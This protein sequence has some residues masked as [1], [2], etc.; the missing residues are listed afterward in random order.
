MQTLTTTPPQTQR[1]IFTVSELT[2]ALKGLLEEAFP[3]VWVEGEI[4]NL[5]QP[6]SGHVYFT[7]KDE[8]AQIGCALFRGHH[9]RLKFKLEDGLK[10]LCGGRV[11]V[12]EK[13]GS[14][15]LYVET[16]EPKGLGA[17]Q[18]AFEQLKARLA[19]EG[20]F[21]EARK[22]PLPVLP[23]RIG[24]VTS[25]TGAVIR[26]ILRTLGRRFP[27][28]V[29]APVRVQ[30]E[31]AAQEIA[32]AIDDLNA[33]NA[34]LPAQHRLDVMIV[35]R[36]GGSLEDLWAFNEEAVA[37]AI[38]RSQLP[39]ISAVGHEVD[40]TIAD[41]VADVRAAT[42]LDAARMLVH[43]KELAQQEAAELR[44]AL[45]AAI[46][47]QLETLSH[48]LSLARIPEPSA[49]I[50]QYQQRVDDLQERMTLH[51]THRLEQWD[52]TLHRLRDILAARNPVVVVARWRQQVGHLSA[53]LSAR[54]QARFEAASGLCRRLIVRLDALSPTA[55]LA[56]GYS[57]TSTEA[58]DQILLDAKGL[59]T[60][61][62]IKTRLH[63]DTI[64]S[65]IEAIHSKGPAD[66]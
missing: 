14:Y 52:S 29:L 62:R 9:G 15:Q 66:G 38:H 22:R 57:I 41:F 47:T 3:Q 4:S 5:S 6:A 48:R 61:D 65:T 40:W 25:P 39:V 12:Y 49:L 7:L 8:Q 50:E 16:V 19:K 64:T 30:G 10:V 63:Q 33:W 13:R 37:R 45:D 43:Q 35:G 28:V 24:L 54:W 46:E 36:G 17:L 55:I 56:R 18:L 1:H 20:L 27:S 11:S 32:Q 34:T 2:R 53:L 59:Q 31:G 51:L 23:E 21:D 26:D 60:G 58:H 42:P 44:T